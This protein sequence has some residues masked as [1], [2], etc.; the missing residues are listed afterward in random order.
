[1]ITIKSITTLIQ[2]QS[3]VKFYLNLIYSYIDSGV[4]IL[5]TPKWMFVAT[6]V[7]PYNKNKGM[8]V[9]IDGYAY[10]GIMNIQ[11]IEKVWPA[12]AGIIND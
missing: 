4:T 7:A 5:I 8:P 10:A 1:M 6:L 2:I 3:Q 9:Y 11:E 12:T